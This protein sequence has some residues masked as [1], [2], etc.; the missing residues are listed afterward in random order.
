[1]ILPSRFLS[2]VNSLTVSPTFMVIPFSSVATCSRRSSF[3]LD[4]IPDG[5]T[6]MNLPSEVSTWKRSF[7]VLRITPTVEALNS[8]KSLISYLLSLDATVSD[9]SVALI[10]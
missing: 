4:A 5:L 10:K 3:N 2:L 8:T 9:V 7:S 1:R 6:F